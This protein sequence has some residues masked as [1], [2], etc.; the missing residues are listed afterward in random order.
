MKPA[1]LLLAL[2]AT[3]GP[4]FAGLRAAEA[5]AGAPGP[6]ALKIG[7]RVE[8]LSLKDIRWVERSLED[9][10]YAK[11]L[12]L[13]FLDTSCPVAA[14]Y[15]PKLN[16]LAREYERRGVLILGVN[17]SPGDTLLAMAADALEKKIEF[18]VFKDF[19][20]S[21]MRALAVE[22]TP[23]TVLLDAGRVLRYR[24]RID[25]QYRPAGESPSEGRK[26]LREALDAVLEGRLP[27]VPEA[28][29]EGCRITQRQSPSR[30]GVNF[31]EHIAP[32]LQRRCQECHRPGLP[33]PFPLLEYEDAAR[34]SSSI[35][36]V[37]EE[38]RMPPSYND[39][40]HGDFVNRRALTEEEVETIAA[41][42]DAG[43]PRGDPSKL[44]QPI[45][46]PASEWQIGE[47][48]QIL[49]MPREFEVPTT[50][51]VEYQYADLARA[52]AESS[53]GAGTVA[54][55]VASEVYQFPHDAWVQSIQILPGDRKAL[56]H[57]N[58][59]I[60]P[61]A[62]A[63]ARPMFVTG[64]VPGGEVT[65]YGD[66]CGILVAAGSRLRLQLH[67]VTSGRALR[68]RTRVGIVFAK[69]IV[70]RRTRVLMVIN[71]KFEIPPQDPAYEVRG[72]GRLARDTVGVGLYCHMHLRGKDMTFIARYPDGSS[73]T[74]LSVPNYDFNWQM[75]YRWAEGRKRL[76]AGTVVET[77]SHYD[78]SRLNP[79]NPDPS[80]TVREGQ[81]TYQ[82][83][84]YGFLFYTEADE[85]LGVEVEPGTGRPLGVVQASPGGSSASSARS[86]RL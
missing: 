46:W 20:Q 45:E 23:E 9:F 31:S 66:G 86:T 71:N 33:A 69:G 14:R 84:N 16:T 4:R 22:R 72:S 62:P 38:R 10:A 47:P 2:L 39:P 24:G 68:D 49:A 50:G 67:Y 48:D 83:M 28:A 8:R 70:E 43:A 37:V 73:E 80:S 59:Y 81:Q 12:V 3:C 6:R 75:S 1:A 40:R 58:L 85:S 5:S 29:A 52:P 82:E 55:G 41:W 36:E 32:I 44:P 64:Y 65:R 18:A 56:H 27:S 42:V 60:V 34:R 7:E 26:Y 78:N 63:D 17:S 51:Y 74:L 13:V 35:R 53:S 54:G 15:V 19:D 77:I 61:P 76:P 11:A 25:E 79:F 30:P 57:A 21:A